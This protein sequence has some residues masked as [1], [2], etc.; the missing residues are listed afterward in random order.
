[1][2]REDCLYNTFIIQNISHEGAHRIGK[3]CIKY[4]VSLIYD[5]LPHVCLKGQ[6][7][8]LVYVLKPNCLI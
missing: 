7:L 2:K 5:K 4:V 3:L 8:C 1:M 6:F